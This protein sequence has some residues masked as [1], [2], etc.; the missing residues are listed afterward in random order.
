MFLSRRSSVHAC[1]R[2]PVRPLT[3]SNLN[4]LL[5][6]WANRKQILSEA[7][8]GLGKGCLIF[9]GKLGKYYELVSMVTDDSH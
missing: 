5:V 6:R 8:F 9:S 1:V 3:L 7:S 4:N 2:V